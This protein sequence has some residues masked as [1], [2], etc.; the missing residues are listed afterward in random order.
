M[1]KI[2]ITIKCHQVVYYDQELLVTKE[3]Y[4]KLS[5]VNGDDV[6][7]RRHQEEYDIIRNNIDYKDIIDARAEF[8]SFEMGVIDQQ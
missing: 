4:E 7:M 3:E 8:E 2:K 1:E 6:S 5:K